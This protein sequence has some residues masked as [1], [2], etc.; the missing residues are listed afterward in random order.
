M[1]QSKQTTSN[2]EKR[3]S[4]SEGKCTCC[5]TEGDTM[6]IDL[7]CPFKPNRMSMSGV[8]NTEKRIE[9][10]ESWEN[11]LKDIL[12]EDDNIGD[13]QFYINYVKD[14]LHSEH[15]KLIEELVDELNRLPITAA[16]SGR[17]AVDQK[18]IDDLITKYSSLLERKEK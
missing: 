17:V 1:N 14:L 15:T 5:Y 18:Y 6:N 13:Y 12:V 9:E 3:K 4:L 7:N 8:P 10:Q 2:T 11:E 16:S